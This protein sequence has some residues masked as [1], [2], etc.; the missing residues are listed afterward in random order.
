M[1]RNL[2]FLVLIFPA[3]A[4]AAES[5]ASAIVP[6]NVT[7]PGHSMHGDSFDEGPRRSAYLLGTTGRVTFPITTNSPLVQQYFHQGI[8]QLHG[9]WYFEAERSFRTAAKLDPDCA[10]NYFGMALA[11]TN[12]DKRAK[13]FIAEAVKRMNQ[14]TDREK[15]YINALNDWYK[16]E[17]SDKDKNKERAQAYINALEE[18]IYLYPDD[19]EA[20][21]MLCLTLWQR[22]SDLGLRSYFAIDALAND[23]LAV[24]QYHPIHHYRIHLWD[25]DKAKMAIHS[26]ERCGLSAPGIAHM[27]HMSGHT[28]SE[29]DQYFDAAWHQE[30]SART[31]H[32]YMMRDGIFPDQIHNFAHNNEWLVKNL[33]YLG[34]VHD[35]IALAKNTIGLPQHPKFNPFPGKKSAHFGRLRLFQIYSDFERWDQLITDA[36]SQ[37]L[38]PT[39]DENEQI[40]YFRNLG[41]AYFRRNDVAN[42]KH[43]LARLEH[44]LKRVK[45]D[46]QL[47]VE[48]AI[49]K[50][51]FDGLGADDIEKKRKE[52]EK[53]T[54]EK[55]KLL[56][57]GVDELQGHLLCSQSNFTEALTRF[58]AAH[59]VDDTFV[60]DIE[61]LAGKKDEALKRLVSRSERSKNQVR[62][63]AALAEMQWRQE[64]KSEARQTFEKLREISGAIDLDFPP[65]AR[66]QPIAT[67]LGYGADWRK[68]KPLASNSAELP[69]LSTLGPLTW[70]PVPASEWRLP[71]GHGQV[72]SLADYRGKPVILIFY[73]GEGCLH[74]VE[75]LQAFAAKHRA[76]ADAGL[77]LAAITTETPE[78]LKKS[79]D[80]YRVDGGFPFQLVANSTLD[81]FK[82]Y[83][84]F[85]DFEAVP[86]H[87]TYLIDAAGKVRWHDVGAEPFRDVDFLLAESQRLLW[88][89]RFELP[90]E[91]KLLNESGPA[92]AL[93]P[94]NQ[95][96]SSNPPDSKK[97]TGAAVAQGAR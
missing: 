34:R 12:N 77:S 93:A 8:G 11:N 37:I 89:D 5:A 3:F 2:T 7:P 73:L 23:V 69:D 9:F 39:A 56:E 26:A 81:V 40:K 57:R 15:R 88:P 19:V 29:L 68:P 28:Y 97:V 83:Q 31:D 18:I 36:H 16:A 53:S 76:F 13:G 4:S 49:A 74:C 20:K 32:A 48:S 61:F 51:R 33:Q 1:V 50:A 62:P 14:A 6:A 84:A 79:L 95:F 87:A 30:A 21:A 64:L 52:A 10:M 22:Q 47:A 65:F 80:K 35:A 66:L 75:Q 27:W 60:A 38:G 94:R 55:L 24:N 46:T 63:L 86:L 70:Q 42:G 41:R 96:P 92:D 59:D 67:Q 45:Q 17:T 82:Q 58:N 72:R 71:D 54:A 44:R 78:V 25:N 90:V 91:P 43:Q 85:D